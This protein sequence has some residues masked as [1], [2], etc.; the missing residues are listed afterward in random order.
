MN[1]KFNEATKN[2]PEGSRV[3]DGE[4]VF[5]DLPTLTRQIKSED[6]WYRHDRNSIT[7]FKTDEMCIVLGALHKNAEMIPH[8]AEGTMNI[9]ALEG[10]LELFTDTLNTLLYEGQ[11]ATIHR[12]SNFRIA[13]RLDSV[14]LLT[15]TGV[16][17]PNP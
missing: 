4:S 3:L 9:Q 17:T 7:V 13:A 5:I 8:K 16:K 10:M 1:D 14:Y 12:D 15:I 6:A 2:R 11:M